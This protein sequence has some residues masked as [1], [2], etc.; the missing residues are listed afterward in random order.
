MSQYQSS[1]SLDTIRNNPDFAALFAKKAEVVK[2]NKASLLE[3]AKSYQSKYQNEIQAGTEKRKLLLA[4]GKSKGL[5]EEETF[6]NNKLFIPTAQTPILNYLYFLLREVEDPSE[7]LKVLREHEDEVHEEV[8][9]TKY[10]KELENMVSFIYKGIGD[11]TFSTIKKLKTMS[12]SDNDKEAFVAF[13]KGRE[14]CQKYNLEWDKI[15]IN[16]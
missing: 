8:K 16:R 15:P 13:R 4:E 1:F 11:D 9:S 5:S 12:M 14:L 6:V 10:N 7:A 2:K 3:A